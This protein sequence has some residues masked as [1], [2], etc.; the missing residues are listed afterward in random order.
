MHSLRTQPH[1]APITCSAA[2]LTTSSGQPKATTCNEPRRR[3]NAMHWGSGV[4]VRGRGVRRNGIDQVRPPSV[5]ALFLSFKLEANDLQDGVPLEEHPKTQLEHL[6]NRARTH[7]LTEAPPH[8]G[9][10]Q[11]F[12]TA[13]EHKHSNSTTLVSPERPL[14]GPIRKFLGLLKPSPMTLN[15]GHSVI[16]TRHRLLARRDIARVACMCVSSTVEMLRDVAD[17]RRL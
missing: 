14:S 5:G 2:K 15:C 3:G 12:R 8:V 16:R 17:E 13:R 4:G 7:G 9:T 11:E 6:R 1:A 10:D